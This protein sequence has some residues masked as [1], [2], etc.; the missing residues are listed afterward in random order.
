MRMWNVDPS[1]MC[2]QHLLGEH[3]EMHMFIG[4]V[5]AGKS[6]QGYIDNKLVDPQQIKQRH[7]TLVQEM[8]YRNYFHNSP[9][10]FD[11]SQLPIGT[12]NIHE[13]IDILHSR[14]DKCSV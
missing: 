7:D 3:L 5:K 1:K 6:L 13:S 11:C 2:R 14:C 8:K 10:D 12:V 4:A 9:I